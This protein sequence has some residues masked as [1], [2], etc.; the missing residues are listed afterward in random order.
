MK[1][2]LAVCVAALV[3]GSVSADD[4]KEEKKIDAAKL[5]GKWEITKTQG[6][7]PKGTIVEMTKDGKL[8]VTAEFNG[9]KL[10]LEGSYSVDGEKLKTKIKGPDGS[11]VEDTDTIK[12]VTDDKLVI[13]DKDGKESELTKMKEKK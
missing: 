5:V 8:K 12:S 10:E 11:E 9:K 1:R 6:D 4:K 7:V 2:L 13:S 3:V